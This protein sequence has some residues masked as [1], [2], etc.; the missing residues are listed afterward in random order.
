MRSQRYSFTVICACVGRLFG[1]ICDGI[2]E[3][4]AKLH[5]V[6]A[7]YIQ[8]DKLLLLENLQLKSFHPSTVHVGKDNTSIFPHSFPRVVQVC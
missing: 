4:L 7:P 1:N 8:D 3:A 6:T 2:T 5:F